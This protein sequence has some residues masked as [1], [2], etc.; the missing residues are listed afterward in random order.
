V[1]DFDAFVD[2][3]DFSKLGISLI[4]KAGHEQYDPCKMLKLVLYSYSYG[5]TRSSRR[6]DRACHHNLSFI[7]LMG[8][9]KPG[10]RSIIRFRAQH[11]KAI[12][13]VLIECA[14]MCIKMQ[15]IEGNMLFADGSK[16]RANAS[17]DKTFTKDDLKK[18]EQSIDFLLKDAQNVD[19]SEE[20][21][22]SYVQL[23]ETI[24]DRR[25]LVESMREYLKELQDSE[26]TS[27]NRVDPD[28]VV[29]KSR[30]GIHAVHNVQCVTDEKHGLIVHAEAV[31]EPGDI[32]QLNPRIEAL[33]K[34]IGITPKVLCTDAGYANPHQLATLHDSI[35]VV[36]PSP[37]QAQQEKHPES[38]LEHPFDKKYFTY[39]KERNVY[40]CPE[41]KTLSYIG[42]LPQRPHRHQYRAKASDCRHCPHWGTCTNA[43]GGRTV[44]RSDFEE[45]T[46]RQ[47]QLYAS[48]YWQHIYRQRQQKVELPFG[49][50]KRTLG[51]GQFLL[52]GNLKVNAEVSLLATC[53]NLTRMIKLLT[54]DGLIAAL[55][56]IT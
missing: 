2:A 40:I 38:S 28:S 7:W 18:I 6:M 11:A 50:L 14:K 49:H 16:F 36:M 1:R 9:L 24:E 53:F 12:R 48:K 10:Y 4:P 39:D 35:A 17:L 52:R 45:Q 27:V 46:R 8:G 29:A 21:H 30:Q 51:A 55:R 31:S 42:S 23:K 19:Q 25:Q 20:G 5:G 3:L 33:Q 34:D 15:L 41:G 26:R 44:T 47:E 43:V 13:K 37:R 32:N 22:G 54:V 56:T